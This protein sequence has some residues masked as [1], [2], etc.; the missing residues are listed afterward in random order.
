MNLEKYNLGKRQTQVIFD[1][2]GKLFEANNNPLSTY[3]F[4]AIEVRVDE[5][6]DVYVVYFAHG[7]DGGVPLSEVVYWKI[8]KDGNKVDIKS[9]YNDVTAL[10]NYIAK[11]ELIK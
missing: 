5:Y 9:K 4:D 8:D 11:L 7:L 6:K 1:L 2:L 10:A 3:R